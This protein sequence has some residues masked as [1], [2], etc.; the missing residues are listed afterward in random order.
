MTAITDLASV[1]QAKGSHPASV[2]L[3]PAM[4]AGLLV[5]VCRSWDALL[6]VLDEEHLVN[7]T[8]ALVHPAVRDGV[9]AFTLPELCRLLR[10]QHAI[11][12]GDISHKDLEDCGSYAEALDDAQSN[13]DYELWPL[14]SGRPTRDACRSCRARKAVHQWQ[15]QDT[16][17]D[18]APV[19][20]L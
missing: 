2:L 14:L 17:S 1:R 11:E 13:V 6:D 16:C 18:H 5:A 3:P 20:A 8:S 10:V 4:R 7:L 12:V 19:R 9:G 15:P